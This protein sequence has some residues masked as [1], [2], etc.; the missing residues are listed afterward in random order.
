MQSQK[1]YN[2]MVEKKFIDNVQ[3]FDQMMNENNHIYAIHKN[4]L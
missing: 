4:P 1:N 3:K 2:L